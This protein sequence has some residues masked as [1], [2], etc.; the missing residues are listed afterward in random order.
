VE[1]TQAQVTVEQLT[2]ELDVARA[3][4]K[5]RTEERDESRR[6]QAATADV[7]K[8]ISSSGFDLQAVFETLV[9]FAAR[10][11][12]AD[13][14]TILLLDDDHFSLV[15]SYGMPA[16]FREYVQANP[17]GLDRG[18]VSG[19]AALEGHAV[20]VADVLADPEFAQHESQKRGGF[21]T[22]L[23]AP[24]MRE[25][26]PIGAI[27]LTR[28]AVNPFTRQQIELVN[29]FAD[30]AVIAIENARLFDQVQTRT[31]ELT[32]SLE[33]QI[34]T[35]DVLG[36][37]SRSPSQ[38]QPV[39]D[40][41]V[42]T[43]SELCGA[44]DTTI[45]LRE[46]H[47][48]R[49]AAHHGTL[50]HEL[51]A[52]RPI[53]RGLVTGRSVVDRMP[54]HVHD[55]IASGDEF[56]LGRSIAEKFGHRTTLAIPLLR[57]A[58]AVG[59]LMLRRLVVEPFSEKHITLLQ[60]FADQAVIAI[61]N[62]RLFEEVRARTAELTDALEQQTATAEVLK[63]ISRSAFDLQKVLNTLV[64]SA[65]MLCGADMG[66]IRR[67]E[68]TSYPVAATYGYKPEWRD[69]IIQYASSPDRTSIFGRTAL[70]GLTIHIPDVLADPE[71]ERPQTQQILGFRAALGVPLLRDGN[72]IGVLVLQRFEPGEFTSK[73]IELVETFA[74][75][76]VIAIENVRL[77]EEVQARTAELQ[78]SLEYQTATS[79]V[80]NV[81]SRA[82]SQLQPVFDAIV[83][84]AA[85]LCEAEFALVYMLRDQKYHPAAANNAEEE[86][87]R[88]AREHPL[89]PGRGSLI[90]RTA[91]EGRT[92]HL[93]DCLADPEYEVLEYQRV[94][95]YRTNLGVPLVRDG[96]T[97]GVIGLMR[98]VVK[99]FSE[100]QIELVETFADQ[101]VIA[102]EN[103]RL[104][105]ELQARTADL[106]EALEQQT[107]TSEVLQVINASPGNLDPVFEAMLAKAT[108]LCNAELGILWTYDGGAFTIAAERG[109]PPPSSIFGN[110]PVRPGPT[111]GLARIAREKHVVH[112]PDLREDQGYRAGD[113]IRVA[114]VDQ[115]GMRSWLG[116]P[117]LKE[118]NLVGVFTIYR[119]EIRPF[120]DKEIALLTSFA[121]QAVIA[122][123]NVRLFEEVQAR[124]AELQES[125]EYQTATGEVLN[126][127]SRSPSDI[128]PVLDAIAETAQRLCE[129]EHVF[130]MR[131]KDGLYHLASAKDAS[132]E[133]LKY[134]RENPLPPDRGSIAGRVALEGQTI[135]IP[136][137]L[138]DPEYSRS[139]LQEIGRF[140]TALGV[141]LLRD[142]AAIGVI[143]LTRN[144]V[145]PFTERQIDLVTTFADQAVIAINNVGLFGEVQ[146]RTA[147]LQESLEYQT[148]TSDVLNVISRSPNQVQPVL[149]AIVETAAR[150]CGA[151][152]AMAFNL[153]DGKF[154]LAA[155]HGG[156]PEYADY[157][158]KSPPALDTSTCS[159]RTAI[160]RRAVYIE[161]TLTEPGYR[162]RDAAAI[163]NYRTI[164]GVPLLREG[165]VIGVIC[166]VHKTVKAFNPRQVDLVTTFADQAVIA[167]HNVGLFEEVQVR[168]RE[169]AR[170]VSE[171]QALSDVSH[172]VNSTLDLETVL[173]TIVAKAVQ[174]SATDA[175]AIYVFSHLRQKFRLRATYGMSPEMIDAI[176][177][178]RIGLGESYIG[179]ASH[180]REPLQVPDLAEDPPSA[181]RD[182]VLASG[183]RALLVVPLLRSDRIVG[184]LVVRRKEPGQFPKST[185]DL[186][187]T[188]AAQSVLA[189]QN[190]RL[191]SEIE[192]KS[193]EIEIASRHKSQ[194]LAN[195]SHELRTPLNAIIG[196]TEMLR[197]EAEGPQFA[198]FTEPLER[199]HRAGKHLLQLINDVL[200]LSK[201]EA[202]KVELHE[203]AF[204]LAALARE[205]VVTAQPLAE[206]NNNL[207]RLECATDLNMF[208]GDQMRV[209]QVL[210]NL[211]SNACKFTEKGAV[212]LSITP[213]R[214]GGAAGVAMSVTD[215][216]IG[217]TAEQLAK[218]FSDF[219][220]ADVSTTRKYGGTGLGLAIS[221][222][223]VEMMGGTIA[224]ESTP[225][226]GSIFRVW[227]PAI[228]GAENALQAPIA[229]R[230]DGAEASRKAV[231]RTVLVIDDDP[232]ARDL[233]RRFLAREGFD[234]VT[235]ADAAE[236][237]RLARQFK[238]TLITL[239]VVMPRM[240]GWSVLEAIKADP[241]L[242]A[243][244]VVMLSILDEQEKGFAL[245]AAD[246]LTKPFDRER[247]RKVLERHRAARPCT[248]VLVV[249]D[250]DATRAVLRDMLLRE[251]C[252]VDVAANGVAALARVENAR[253]DIILLD[254]I[255]P[256]MNG[257]EFVD[258]LRSRPGGRDIP[259]VVLT[260][261]DLSQ[262]ER[263]RLAGETKTVLRKSMHSRGELAAELRRA[264]R[265]SPE[266][267]EPA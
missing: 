82:P 87:V 41:I 187:K 232:D 104:F 61:E 176:S 25:G 113:P 237:L 144:T 260:A 16:D 94:G 197:E 250:E 14:A 183:Y 262:A 225:G 26:A 28:A 233:M 259:I 216:G 168:T 43:A 6:Q 244:P 55:I 30:Q 122:I 54:V 70:E 174:L 77:F 217:M 139:K 75:Q 111:T 126:V 166:L 227:L 72:Q 222:R 112:I 236:G 64:E 136:D 175:G 9:D 193:R 109:T 152:Y 209:R 241:E 52:R 149:D 134:L 167:I 256:G 151:D 252:E 138:A 212:T 119:I 23:A 229:S 214:D 37:I 34:A 162:R 95:R 145:R 74:D 163:G 114:S 188:F 239:D 238:P 102:I 125:L 133:H 22:V 170:S 153:R 186:L 137:V 10:L 234:T 248:R 141:P 253:P 31:A 117:L 101:A 221:K 165:E 218:I 159:G 88:Y 50:P 29:T 83:G 124:T 89:A 96:T 223:L 103:V 202:G 68:G 62:A 118:G 195:M 100:K 169:L 242:A 79:D 267:T 156:P 123:E 120:S 182:L 157:L 18:S 98:T 213:S 66:V 249:E 185:I 11:C 73:Q 15:A 264:L 39:L 164:F 60:T 13:K 69:H 257:F 255:M 254:L 110:Q 81:I 4:L 8:V 155:L 12:R 90:G 99:P 261:K 161:D 148:A 142:G 228:P 3:E 246:Y 184:A 56:P 44:E 19:R 80:L 179:T 266:E 147:E 215:T 247:L 105:E 106:S 143:V 97:I 205:L 131:L 160:E 171:L 115:L 189:I 93:P 231:T 206:K 199:V 53:D 51:N 71:F 107:A 140:R 196:L 177:H 84:T 265:S 24:L 1:R 191:F 173:D 47:E 263:E 33:Y 201:I 42:Q 20:H 258:V 135:Q 204:D 198:D 63:V 5:T 224:V 210:L 27:F 91:L 181:M 230:A 92:V 40:T 220:Q 200:D 245:G 211:L 235:A 207:L 240:D 178:Q 38:L 21:R 154:S 59:S 45:L 65:A 57:E 76:A 129:S 172:A 243:I 108:Q 219:T 58:D 128:Q 192:Q 208:R 190:A 48:L 180:R 226:Q 251:G 78:Q 86:F 116:V 127:I 36:V 49:V 32:E 121:D 67:R 35:S 17:F 203:D 46:K 194:F 132:E 146:A 130:I 2:R 158:R 7:L 85:R 150:L